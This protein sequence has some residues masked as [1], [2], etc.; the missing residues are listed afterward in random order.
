MSYKRLKKD[1]ID[2]VL[3]MTAYQLYFCARLWL[4]SAPSG[5]KP[6]ML[7]VWRWNLW[8]TRHQY[9][10]RCH[11]LQFKNI[12]YV[13]YKNKLKFSHFYIIVTAL[14]FKCVVFLNDL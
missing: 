13:C 9:C 1:E 10:A 7:L 12:E 11:G 3:M 2:N 5:I 6:S 14:V 4:K 8:S